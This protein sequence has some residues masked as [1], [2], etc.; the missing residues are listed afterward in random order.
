MPLQ[1]DDVNFMDFSVDPDIRCE[2][3]EALCCG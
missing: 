2:N 3:A 1:E